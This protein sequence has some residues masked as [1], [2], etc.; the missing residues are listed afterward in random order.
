MTSS[1]GGAQDGA[2]FFAIQQRRELTQVS[3]WDRGRTLVKA[4]SFANR[5]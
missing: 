5:K 3:A 2:K 4:I 1:A